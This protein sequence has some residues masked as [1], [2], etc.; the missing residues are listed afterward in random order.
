MADAD[1]GPRG[2]RLLMFL[3]PPRQKAH[4]SQASSTNAC[5][6]SDLVPRFLLVR[7]SA[8]THNYGAPR[9]PKGIY[10]HSGLLTLD[11]RQREARA[12]GLTSMILRFEATNPGPHAKTKPMR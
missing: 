5:P 7:L 9:A 3:I 1:S 11:T 12:L 4:I 6:G 8:N 2:L 10:A